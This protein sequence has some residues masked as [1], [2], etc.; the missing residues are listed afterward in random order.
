MNAFDG[1]HEDQPNERTIGSKPDMKKNWGFNKETMDESVRPQDDFYTY[2]NGMWIRETKIPADESRWGSFIE[3]RYATE[4]KLRALVTERD[5]TGKNTKGTPEQM[6]FDFYDSAT[7]MDKRNAL[8]LQPIEADRK[9]IQNLKNRSE[10]TGLIADLHRKSIGVFGGAGVEPDMKNSDLNILYFGQGGLGMPEREYYLLDEPEQKRVR[11]AYIAHVA[12]MFRLTGANEETAEKNAATV[13]ALETRLAKA[14]MDKVSLRD[15]EKLYH[16][17]TLAELQ[18]EIPNFQWAEYMKLIGAGLPESVILLQPEFFAEM[19]E[20]LTSASLDDIKVYMEWCLLSGQAGVLNESMLKESFNFNGTVLGGQ[21]EMQPLWRRSLASVNGHIGELFGQ[22]YVKKHFGPEEK[23]RMDELVD[24][25]FAAYQARILAL[26]W[27]GEETKKKA[28]EKLHAMK[29]KIG[30]PENWKTYDGLDIISR[31]YYGNSER[32][33]EYEHNRNINKLKV[34]VDR[35]EWHMSPQ[36]VNAYY[37]LEMNDMVF[38]AAILQWP[39]FDPDADDALNYGAI[40]YTIGHEMTH[41]F[42]DQGSKF[43]ARGNLVE[44]WTE[45]DR[46]QFDG[47]TKIVEEQ[48]NEFTVEDGVHLNGKLTLGENIA[49]LGGIQIAYD[50]YQA[51]LKKTRRK[52]ID[53][54][55]PEQ[56]FFLAVAQQE[57]EVRRAEV[58]KLLALNDHHSPAKYRI[59]GPLS[60]ISEFYEAFGIKE[61]DAMYRSPENRAKIW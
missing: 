32:V 53:G 24:D 18:S 46:K 47:K 27:M 11:D 60:H 16:K 49:D 34:P 55:S 44:W 8:G 5:G 26:D 2:V 36:T 10:L 6:V 4:K 21:K 23:K 54:L 7:D 52:T 20:I 37:S 15:P 9:R 57:R 31:D 58:S 17:K 33:A 38:P 48:Y 14:S 41:G 28:L 13:L 1:G 3:L 12:N 45:E 30:F 39:F 42:D 35:S 40:G 19:G 59:N 51:H 29:R 43:D 25:L 22:L 50:A 56:R 61:G